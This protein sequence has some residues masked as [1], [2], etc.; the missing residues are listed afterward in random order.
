MA[1]VVSFLAVKG[2]AFEAVLAPEG[3]ATVDFAVTAFAAFT[4]VTALT[5]FTALTAF[6]V[7]LG[8]GVAAFFPAGAAFFT[9]LA[10]ILDVAFGTVFVAGF[11]ATLVA[12]LTAGLAAGLAAAFGAA[13]GA[14]FAGLAGFFVATFERLVDIAVTS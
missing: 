13:L 12:A 14:A 8:E 10:G 3:F 1:V 7:L 9:V 4:A 2:G 5:V 11:A 6:T